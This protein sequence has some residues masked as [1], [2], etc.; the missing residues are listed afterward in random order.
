MA[1]ELSVEY[2]FCRLCPS[3]CDAEL[4]RNSGSVCAW[5]YTRVSGDILFSVNGS[6]KYPEFILGT[7]TLAHISQSTYFAGINGVLVSMN[8]EQIQLVKCPPLKTQTQSS[9]P[10][11]LCTPSGLAILELQGTLNLPPC[12][13]M[14]DLSLDPSA[15]HGNQEYPIGRLLFPD[16]EKS[17][18]DS[19]DWMKRVYMYIGKHQRLTG[20][21]KKLP[22]ALAII[23]KMA[24]EK[25][26]LDEDETT[27]V[28]LE[29]VEIV[30]YKILF[31]S[32]PEPVTT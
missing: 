10:T 11:L 12:K 22:K 6:T 5:E 28:Q 20:E 15:G 32:R 16:Y 13:D 24:I 17:G 30:K 25:E 18:T 1:N 3:G 27:S 31:S 21:V 2:Y 19:T 26:G 23:R 7:E 4:L 29:I 8:Q 9:L 14:N